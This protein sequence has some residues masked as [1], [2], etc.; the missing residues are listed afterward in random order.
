M[1]EKMNYDTSPVRDLTFRKG[2]TFREVWKLRQPD[3]T[4]LDLTGV[5]IRMQI[6]KKSTDITFLKQ[7]TIGDGFTLQAGNTELA[8]DTE[9]LIQEGKWVYDVRVIYPDGLVDFF[10]KGQLNINDAVTETP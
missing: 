10:C 3:N 7:L 5:D 8:I 1:A 6:K 4:Y 2:Q 9:M